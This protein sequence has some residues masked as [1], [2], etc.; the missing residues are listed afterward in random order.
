MGKSVALLALRHLAVEVV[1][2]N[3]GIDLEYE[4]DPDIL[5]VTGNTYTEVENVTRPWRA[6]CRGSNLHILV[7]GVSQL[8]VDSK[9]LNV[10][11]NEST[12]TVKQISLQ[13][14]CS[15][16]GKSEHHRRS[17]R[18]KQADSKGRNERLTGDDCRVAIEQISGQFTGTDLGTTMLT[19][20][21]FCHERPKRESQLPY[22][23]LL[24]SKWSLSVA[25]PIELEVAEP[26]LPSAVKITTK[27]Q[28][29]TLDVSHK[30]SCASC[31][32]WDPVKVPLLQYKWGLDLVDTIVLVK[33]NKLFWNDPCAT[34]TTTEDAVVGEAGNTERRTIPHQFYPT[35]IP[36]FVHHVRAQ[37][38][39]E[40]YPMLRHNGVAHTELIY[41][42]WHLRF[43]GTEGRLT[44]DLHPV[45]ADGRPVCADNTEVR[46][47]EGSRPGSHDSPPSIRLDKALSGLGRNRQC[48]TM[49]VRGTVE[50]VASYLGCGIDAYLWWLYANHLYRCYRVNKKPLPEREATYVESAKLMAKNREQIELGKRCP[51]LTNQRTSDLIKTISCLRST[52]SVSRLLNNSLVDIRVDQITVRL[53]T[54][55]SDATSH[56]LVPETVPEPTGT[57]PL[58]SLVVTDVTVHL[59]PVIGGVCVRVSKVER[60]PDGIPDGTRDGIPDGIPDGITDRKPD[61]RPEGK[62]GLFTTPDGHGTDHGAGADGRD[63][64]DAFSQYGVMATGITYY[65]PYDYSR[66]EVA[67][68]YC[69]I[70]GDIGTLTWLAN[71][72]WSGTIILY[73]NLLYKEHCPAFNH[74]RQRGG[75]DQNIALIV[76][77]VRVDLAGDSTSNTKPPVSNEPSDLE[78]SSLEPSDHKPSRLGLAGARVC[79]GRSRSFLVPRHWRFEGVHFIKDKRTNHTYVRADT[80]R[81]CEYHRLFLLLGRGEFWY[82]TAKSVPAGLGGRASILDGRVVNP[83]AVNELYYSE[84]PCDVEIK[85][86]SVALQFLNIY[87][88]E[89]LDN[90]GAYMEES[91]SKLLTFSNIFSV[92]PP[93]VVDCFAAVSKRTRPAF[94]PLAQST[95]TCDAFK[96]Q[97]HSRRNNPPRAQPASNRGVKTREGTAH[98]PRAHSPRVHSPRVHSP[99]A[100]SPRTSVDVAATDRTPWLN[101]ECEI[102]HAQRRVLERVVE[103]AGQRS[104]VNDLLRPD[105]NPLPGAEPRQSADNQW[106]DN[107]ISGGSQWLDNQLSG[108]TLS[109]NKWSDT[110]WSSLQYFSQCSRLRRSRSVPF[111]LSMVRCISEEGICERR[112]YKGGF[113]E[114]GICEG[115]SPREL[116]AERAN[117][118]QR[119]PVTAATVKSLDE[120]TAELLGPDMCRNPVVVKE[121]VLMLKELLNSLGDIR[122][123]DEKQPSDDVARGSRQHFI[124]SW[125]P[126]CFNIV[127]KDLSTQF[128]QDVWVCKPRYNSVAVTAKEFKLQGAKPFNEFCVASIQYKC[129]KQFTKRPVHSGHESDSSRGD[130]QDVPSTEPGTDWLQERWSNELNLQGNRLALPEANLV[131]YDQVRL[132]TAF[133]TAC[134]KCN[135]KPISLLPAAPKPTTATTATATSATATTTTATTATATTT[136]ATTATATA[137]TATATTATT[138]T[139]TTGTAAAWTTTSST[140]TST[141]TVPG[142]AGTAPVSAP[143][144]WVLQL[145]DSE[146]SLY[147]GA[148]T[149]SAAAA[150]EACAESR[151]KT[152]PGGPPGESTASLCLNIQ[153]LLCLKVY[154]TSVIKLRPPFSLSFLD[155]QLTVTGRVLEVQPLPSTLIILLQI[156]NRISSILKGYQV[157]KQ[158]A[159]T[160]QN[161]PAQD[162]PAQEPPGQDHLAPDHDLPTTGQ[163]MDYAALA[164]QVVLALHTSD[165]TS[166]QDECE[167]PLH[168][169]LD[170][171]EGLP[172]K[173]NVPTSPS[174]PELDLWSGKSRSRVAPRRAAS[175]SERSTWLT[176]RAVDSLSLS[177]PRDSRSGGPNADTPVSLCSPTI[178]NS[179]SRSQLRPTLEVPQEEERPEEG[180]QRP[181]EKSRRPAGQQRPADG[182]R[183]ECNI[184]QL[185]VRLGPYTNISAKLLRYEPGVASAGSVRVLQQVS[186]PACSHLACFHANVV[187]VL[188]TREPRGQCRL[189]LGSA[190]MHITPALV[191]SCVRSN[192]LAFTHFLRNYLPLNGAARAHTGLHYDTCLPTEA[193]GF[194]H[195]GN[196][197]S[198][199]AS[200]GWDAAYGCPT[201][202]LADTTDS[203]PA[204][205]VV[206]SLRNVAVHVQE[207]AFLTTKGKPTPSALRRWAFRPTSELAGEHLHLLNITQINLD[208]DWRR[209]CSREPFSRDPNPCNRD[210]NPSNHYPNTYPVWNGAIPREVL[211]DMVFF[212]TLERDH[213]IAK[214]WHRTSPFQNTTG[215]LVLETPS[216]YASRRAG[217]WA[218]SV[219]ELVL[220]GSAKEAEELA[221]M[222]LVVER[223]I[224]HTTAAVEKLLA[225]L[226][227][228]QTSRLLTLSRYLGDMFA[229]FAAFAHRPPRPDAPKL[230]R[231]DTSGT[232][233]EATWRR[234]QDPPADPGRLLRAALDGSSRTRDDPRLGAEPLAFTTRNLR[235]AAI[236]RKLTQ[237]VEHITVHE[238]HARAFSVG[239]M[240]DVSRAMFRGSNRDPRLDFRSL[241]QRSVDQRSVDQ[242]SVAADQRS[243]VADQRS[244]DF[245]EPVL[246]GPTD[247]RPPMAW[248][249]TLAQGSIAFMSDD[250]Q[251][252][253]VLVSHLNCGQEPTCCPPRDAASGHA[254]DSTDSQNPHEKADVQVVDAQASQQAAGQQLGCADRFDSY[255]RP[256]K[257]VRTLIALQDLMLMT[258]SPLV[259][260]DGNMSPLLAPLNDDDPILVFSSVHATKLI[261][262]RTK[263]VG[264]RKRLISTLMGHNRAG[265]NRFSGEGGGRHHLMEGRHVMDSNKPFKTMAR[266]CSSYDRPL[267]K[268]PVFPHIEAELCEGRSEHYCHYDYMDIRIAP[269][270]LRMSQKLVIEIHN[271]FVAPLGEE[272]SAPSGDLLESLKAVEQQL[273]QTTQLA[274]GSNNPA[275]Q[276]PTADYVSPHISPMEVESSEKRTNGDRNQTVLAEQIKIHAIKMLLTYQGIINIKDCQVALSP[277]ILVNVEAS[278]LSGILN[279]ISYQIMA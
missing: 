181:Q 102:R 249:V 237:D 272:E 276:S 170:V 253:R 116:S 255:G 145:L 10:L 144:R 277:S 104:T 166:A 94:F 100:P 21:R 20:L 112:V 174:G 252:L 192:V 75:L 16:C 222:D 111:D 22:N 133:F 50:V 149:V 267:Y 194:V 71:L 46:S 9:D 60:I 189:S 43:T 34:D 113:C 48:V 55:A 262:R 12:L 13:C 172:P 126:Q 56:H 248:S 177:S 235:A 206:M 109:D 213:V 142:R 236:P 160:A 63:P 157:R 232:L 215:G 234:P 266:G 61:G 83:Q 103:R 176:E 217:A 115:G 54:L 231:T 53:A 88:E 122:R 242:R 139:A 106:L 220:R 96:I 238:P 167:G 259:S 28:A 3:Y 131:S 212:V 165:M 114:G 270:E 204:L 171:P 135:V 228:R 89:P 35:Y 164:E 38:H 173:R 47:P 147:D 241:D 190:T 150:V 193:T 79:D 163:G 155:R 159:Q 121:L 70:S 101:T 93:A 183:F 8:L 269:V 125:Q 37:L 5:P 226:N 51:W 274:D 17:T 240:D 129:F 119:A 74:F 7:S 2:G 41:D 225:N 136:T 90:F 246:H 6:S 27:V 229:Q 42:C 29:G 224:T 18:S 120:I 108:T 26:T 196:C 244:G 243:V 44:D 154:G 105:G 82:G 257:R 208:P 40:W 87:V 80:A 117:T 216:V 128:N 178:L 123:E 15:Q 209:P 254:P 199:G 279:R 168:S 263:S 134:S 1:A 132:V 219:P 218:V 203:R 58:L 188:C 162:Q 161:P 98:S 95:Y 92:P 185:I 99:R 207:T 273:L 256:V 184:E 137:T 202:G 148:L 200:H 156:Q 91:L 223:T 275:S 49:K 239:S 264:R 151:K 32:S 211:G 186:D 271:Y 227:R 52:W 265:E 67:L 19:Y 158:A 72:C 152:K 118:R 66:S 124:T 31:R 33:V 78:V 214:P 36:K 85:R 57:E 59:S 247:S 73:I 250:L 268:R 84:F 146:V 197:A 210:T 81:A 69:Y 195:R 141:P 130:G 205:S 64:W 143:A 180:S 77:K 233:S 76:N 4:P 68:D 127:A 179:H 260:D 30:V 153:A 65:T 14:K 169:R 138:A 261:P 62:T 107:Q 191:V 251:L 97:V 258:S 86:M 24:W 278:N 175:G 187:D 140:T 25:K 45:A 198:H 110:D 182:C 201:S 230:L 11:V 221:R 245:L 39:D 23:A